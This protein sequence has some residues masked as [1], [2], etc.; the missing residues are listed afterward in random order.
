MTQGANELDLDA[1]IA[2]RSLDPVPVKLGGKT[3]MVRTDLTG[4]EA[5]KF[6]K[7]SNEGKDVDALKMIVPS[8]AVDLNKV[9]EKL[10][11]THMIMVVQKLIQAAGL[12]G[13]TEGESK[14][15]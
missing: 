2:A 14:A 1:L 10:P 12:V 11:R 6:F 15:S 7:L 5:A 8:A 13:S 4:T 3:Y 9:L